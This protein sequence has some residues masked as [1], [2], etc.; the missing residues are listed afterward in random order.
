MKRWPLRRY[1]IKLNIPISLLQF[2][3]GPSQGVKAMR[4][5][6]PRLIEE[7]K[8]KIVSDTNGLCQED[9]IRY[10]VDE[11]RVWYSLRM[12]QNSTSL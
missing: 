10:F 12:L 6:G 4:A 5:S 11:Y 9:S 3:I 7:E 1:E 2:H 8:V